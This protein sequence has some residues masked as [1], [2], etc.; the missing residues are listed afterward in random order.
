M[1]I[2]LTIPQVNLPAQM[3]PNLART[4][5]AMSLHSVQATQGYHPVRMRGVVDRLVLRTEDYMR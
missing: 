3:G 5:Q 1:S 2:P 4:L